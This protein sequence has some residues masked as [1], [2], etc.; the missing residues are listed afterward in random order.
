MFSETGEG[1][2]YDAQKSHVDVP[3][4]FHTAYKGMV[5]NSIF[6]LGLP[7]QWGGGGAPDIL[8]N[9]VMEMLASGNLSLSTCP[10]LTYGAITT[11]D[12]MADQTI[13]EK[14][15]PPLVSGKWSGTMCLTEPQCGTDLGLI[16]TSAV[17]RGDEFLI[18]GNKIWITFGEHK[19]TENIIHLVLARL[20]NAPSGVKGIS[21]FL[22]PKYLDDGRHNGVVC[23]GLEKKMGSHGSP[24]CFMSYDNAIGF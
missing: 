1:L 4:I 15:L 5:E 17:P 21:L 2:R 22:V 9:M 18:N 23:T 12:A 7:A 20:P 16:T 14:Y 13:K 3:D 11:I 8:I 19:L 10:L 24:T 6:G